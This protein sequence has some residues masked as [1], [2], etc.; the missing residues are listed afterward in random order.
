[1]PWNQEYRYDCKGCQRR[2]APDERLSARGKCPACGHGHMIANATQLKLKRGP[3]FEHW[4]AACRAVFEFDRS[5]TE[6]EA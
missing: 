3:Y 1:M 4:Y 5:Q 2:R 6:V